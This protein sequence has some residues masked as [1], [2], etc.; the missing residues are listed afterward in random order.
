M[1]APK[2]LEC[3]GCMFWKPAKRGTKGTCRRDTP[4]V[5]AGSWG[6]YILFASTVSTHWPATD[7]S[8]W[9]GVHEPIPEAAR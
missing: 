2:K 9:C 4:T 7:A 5:L 6:S 8:D 1:S 3:R